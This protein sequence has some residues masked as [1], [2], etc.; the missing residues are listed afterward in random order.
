VQNAM[1]S[2]QQL[3]GLQAV[4]GMA[5]LLV[6][7]HHS[8]LALLKYT[9]ESI[10]DGFFQA[11]GKAGVDV[12]FVLS[13]FIIYLVHVGDINNPDALMRY[14][15]KRFRRIYLPYWAVLSLVIPVYFAKPSFGVGHERTIAAILKSLT[16][17]PAGEAGGILILA[18]AW[19]LAH[20][21]VFY[22]IFG[23][24]ILNRRVG[25]VALIAWFALLVGGQF[26]ADKP[27]PLDFFLYVK[28]LEF[29]FGIM[30][31]MFVHKGINAPWWIG[32]IGA[33]IFVVTGVAEKLTFPFVQS[34]LTL[35][36]GIGAA[37]VVTALASSEMAG[38]SL[39]SLGSLSLIGN[40]SYA[41]Y[42][43]HWPVLSALCKAATASGLITQA[44]WIG[45]FGLLICGTVSGIIFHFVVEKPILSWKPAAV[46]RQNAVT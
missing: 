4:R 6:A 5:A 24:A 1:R 20:E 35:F 14:A 37:L 34:P 13:G 43:V 18:V 9:G 15:R 26:I 21:I 41:I 19:T 36:Y 23:L 32:C 25:R 42:L 27:Y 10:G 33:C 3:I 44:S 7:C 11:F 40:A 8:S 2:R 38:R 17:F 39:R 46:L 28:N 29:F 12:F 31:G 30:A 22:T 45:F 16:L